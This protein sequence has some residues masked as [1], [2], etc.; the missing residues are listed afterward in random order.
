MHRSHD[1]VVNKCTPDPIF[2]YELVSQSH[3]KINNTS[4]TAA[5]RSH[6][7]TGSRSQMQR[8]LT[9]PIRP[10]SEC[11]R[12]ILLLKGSIGLTEN[13]LTK[14]GQVIGHLR[15]AQIPTEIYL[16]R[17]HIVV[18]CVLEYSLWLAPKRFTLLCAEPNY[19]VLSLETEPQPAKCSRTFELPSLGSLQLSERAQ[20]VICMIDLE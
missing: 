8:W 19:S 1:Y 7:Y 20:L 9:K 12:T 16:G 17:L 14:F 13:L 5:L 3:R 4:K 6:L 11:A 18:F 2:R 10:T 15:N